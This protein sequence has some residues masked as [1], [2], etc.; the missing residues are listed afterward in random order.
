MKL[1]KVNIKHMD[2]GQRNAGMC[3]LGN[4]MSDHGA[5]IIRKKTE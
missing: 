3:Q 2:I 4:K 5:R 1:L